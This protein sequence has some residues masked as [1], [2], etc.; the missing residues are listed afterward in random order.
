[1]QEKNIESF[2]EIKIRLLQFAKEQKLIM[3]DFYEKIGVAPSNFSGKAMESALKSDNLV[4]VLKVYPE[5]SADWLLLEKGE[6]LRKNNAKNVNITSGPQSLAG[7]GTLTV[8]A[9]SQLLSII[10]S[11]QETINRLSQTIDRLTFK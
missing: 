1:M 8:E 4:K 10:V 9:P 5:L 2:D 11:Q 6:M 7:D 3:G